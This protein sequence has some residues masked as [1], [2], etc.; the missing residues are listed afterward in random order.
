MPAARFIESCLHEHGEAEVNPGRNAPTTTTKE[1]L[2][3][4]MSLALV[5]LVLVFAANNAFAQVGMISPTFCSGTAP[6]HTPG[7]TT[8]AGVPD[9]VNF[10]VNKNKV[11]AVCHF[12]DTSGIFDSTAQQ[13]KLTTCVISTGT[14][15]FV[16][17]G[18]VVAAANNQGVTGG[19][20]TI[21]C[22]A[23]VP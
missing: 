19:H 14:G 3:K 2:M 18:H 15:T 20:A 17:D 8:I 11:N 22:Q 12:E 10:V 6:G 4:K 23:D 16:G 5:A 21:K 1:M 9:R 7:N 13:G